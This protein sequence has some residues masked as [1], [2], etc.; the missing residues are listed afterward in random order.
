[1][2]FCN[3]DLFNN[4]WKITSETVKAGTINH[5]KCLEP[6]RSAHSLIKIASRNRIWPCFFNKYLT[7]NIIEI[8]TEINKF[9]LKT[10]WRNTLGDK[11]KHFHH[12]PTNLRP[13]GVTAAA[14]WVNKLSSS[15]DTQT[16]ITWT[17]SG[18]LIQWQWSGDKSRR[19]ATFLPSDPTAQWTTISKITKLSFSV[20]GEPTSSVLTL[21]VSSTGPLYNG[22]KSLQSKTKSPLGKEPTMSLN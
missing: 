6:L 8:Y 17:M 21:S 1:M 15:E 2:F 5:F 22:S 19:K 12:H 4:N 10:A 9:F 13:D 14:S 18:P 7:A 11:L 16:P 20:A 3:F